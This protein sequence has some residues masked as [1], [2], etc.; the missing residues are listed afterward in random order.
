MILSTVLPLWL[1][2]NFRRQDTDDL[3]VCGLQLKLCDLH[4]VVNSQK[5]R[6]GD[7]LAISR[8]D[9]ASI[10]PSWTAPDVPPLSWMELGQYSKQQTSLEKGQKHSHDARLEPR[11][12]HCR[13]Q[14]PLNMGAVHI[15]RLPYYILQTK[16][17][18]TN[19]NDS[20]V[21]YI[22]VIITYYI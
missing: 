3:Q 18:V 7:G 10:E 22:I 5:A 17:Y 12:A 8:D 21:T 11:R 16:D 1:V 20:Y 14:M 6:Y 2:D 15:V 9:G 19:G 4:Y 13:S